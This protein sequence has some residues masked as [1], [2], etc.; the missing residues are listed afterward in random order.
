MGNR[1]A[2]PADVAALQAAGVQYVDLVALRRHGPAACA[3][4]FLADQ[5]GQA[6]EGFWIHFDVDVLAHELMPAVDSPQPGGLTY[7]EL[8]ALLVPLL[9]SGHAV[10]L[11]ITILDA[12]KDPTG[13]IT[14]QFVAGLAPILAIMTS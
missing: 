1:D 14:R 4:A 13:E 3:A 5:A 10:G 11:D 2:D 8:A 9:Q 6:V 12:S 7:A